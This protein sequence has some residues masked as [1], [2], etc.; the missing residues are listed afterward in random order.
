MKLMITREATL[1]CDDA[2]DALSSY[3]H[4]CTHVYMYMIG[5]EVNDCYLSSL[6]PF[7][8]SLNFLAFHLI[9][10]QTYDYDSQHEII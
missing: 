6:N 8:F 7:L 5:E 1:Q 9:S 10:P 4:D 3:L 2:V